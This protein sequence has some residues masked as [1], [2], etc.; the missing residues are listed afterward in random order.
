MPSLP[1]AAHSDRVGL[2]TDRPPGGRYLPLPCLEEQLRH[3]LQCGWIG[4]FVNGATHP[5]HFKTLPEGELQWR[6]HGDRCGCLPLWPHP[7]WLPAIHAE[8]AAS[9]HRPA[10]AAAMNWTTI[11]AN[12]GIPDS[13]G[14]PEAIAAAKAATAAKQ[15]AKAAKKTQP[16]G[17]KR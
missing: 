15:A 1:L 10:G 11:L 9:C 6:S 5:F 12:A 8:T 2:L 17:K 7:L 13:P 3:V 14:R 16:K 4:G